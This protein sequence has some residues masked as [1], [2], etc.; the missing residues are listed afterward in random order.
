[1]KYKVGIA[2]ILKLN[3]N[4]VDCFKNWQNFTKMSSNSF[5]DNC[6]IRAF[7]LL[8]LYKFAFVTLTTH[9]IVYYVNSFIN[10]LLITSLVESSIWNKSLELIKRVDY[11]NFLRDSKKKE[12]KRL[13]FVSISHTVT[14]INIVNFSLCLTWLLKYQLQIKLKHKIKA[15]D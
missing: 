9:L 15:S 2:T 7:Y 8:L 4:K 6:S 12:F 13:L 10:D 3:T 14:N 11:Y 1:M 5:L